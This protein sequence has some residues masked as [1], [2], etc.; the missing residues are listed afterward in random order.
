MKKS[1]KIITAVVVAFGLTA[2][3]ATFAG[4]GRWHSSDEHAEYAV[5]FIAK[6]LDLT[7]TQEQSLAALKDQVLIAKSAMH[8]KMESTHTEISGLIGADSFDQ[9][10]ALELITAKTDTIDTVAPELVG[11]L[12]NF[13]DTLNAEQ[14][15]EVLDM[16]NKHHGKRKFGRRH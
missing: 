13:M 1:T 12:G 8:E 4:K 16:L 5:G 2:A 6:K 7:A 10:K 3:G 11:A 9:G 14:K 15:Q